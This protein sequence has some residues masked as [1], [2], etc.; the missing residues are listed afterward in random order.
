M[1]IT[2]WYFQ[3]N[4]MIWRSLPF[5][6][7]IRKSPG[8]TMRLL[9]CRSRSQW[10]SRHVSTS[11]LFKISMLSKYRY[12][13]PCTSSQLSTAHVRLH[14][15][16]TFDSSSI[17]LNVKWTRKYSAQVSVFILIEIS[18]QRIWEV[19]S[20]LIYHANFLHVEIST[21]V[22]IC[23]ISGAHFMGHFYK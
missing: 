14:V 4:C 15:H 16:S 23:W 7:C 20:A 6:H 18:F 10:C 3:R 21:K 9:V 12:S 11:S 19:D 2:R 5:R 8:N 1:C 17:V 13:K 22:C